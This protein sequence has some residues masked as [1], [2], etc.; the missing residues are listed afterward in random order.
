MYEYFCPKYNRQTIGLSLLGVV[1]AVR[2]GKYY[3]TC[4]YVLSIKI[5]LT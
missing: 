3:L 2:L 4:F 5:F 1:V